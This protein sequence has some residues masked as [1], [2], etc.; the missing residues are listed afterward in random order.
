MKKHLLIYFLLLFCL[1]GFATH[2]RA[3]EITYESL[4]NNQYKITIA[5]YTKDSAPAD[6]C[7]LEIN[8]GDGTSSILSRV[9]GVIDNSQGDCNGTRRGEFV[10]ND[11]RKNLYTGTHAY[12]NAGTYILSF[13]DMNRNSGISNIPQSVN[14]PFYVQS[15]LKVAPGVGP[16]SSPV[17]TNPPIDDGC[18]N[19]R[20]EHNPGAFDA[21]GDLLTY[22]L[23]LCREAGGATVP[24]TYDPNIVQAPVTIDSLNGD[25]IWDKPQNIG[26]YNFAIQITEWRQT[27]T[28]GYRQIG[29]VVRDLQIDIKSCNN[30]PPVIQP[31]GPFCVEAGQNLNFNITAIDPDS[32]P[33]LPPASG[34]AYDD[35]TMTAFGGPFEVVFPAD[36]VYA[37]GL[38][39]VTATF[40]WDTKCEH[41]RKL[42][43]QITFKAEDDPSARVTN[44]TKLVDLYTTEIQVVAPAPKNPQAIGAKNAIDLSWD[45]SFCTDAIGYKVYRREGTY[46]FVPDP[47]ETGV[48]AYTGYKFHG[49]TP[50]VD[51]LIFKDTVDL[52]NGVQYCYMVIAHFADSSESYASVEFCSSKQVESPLITNVDI[53][54]T[55]PQNGS[56]DIKWIAPPKIDSATYPPPYSYKLYRADEIDGVNFVEI[57]NFPTIT[58][59]FYNDPALNTE[60]RGYSYKVEF[61]SGT[62]P[63]L[64]STSD[65]ASSVFLEVQPSD[66]SNILRFRHFTPW[67]NDTFVVFRENPSGS[68]VFDSLDVS[69]SNTYIDTGLVNGDSYC[70]KAL[71]IGRYTAPNTPNNLLNNSQI[72]CGSPL[73]T[74]A[75]CPPIAKADTINCEEDE[76]R[77]SWSLSADS[78]CVNDISYFNVYYK[79]SRDGD[80]PAQPMFSNITNF[81]LDITNQS[82][83]GCYAITAVDD[84]GSDPNGQPNESMI[85][86]VI[87]VE[88]CPLINFPNVFTPNGDG[89]NDFFTAINYKDVAKLNIQ[90]FNR[91]GMMV[92]ESKSPIDFFENGWDGSDI[93]T[94]QPCSDGVYFYVARFT[95]TAISEVEEQVTK[96]FVHLFRN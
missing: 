82:V 56:I 12:P 70:Y 90:V 10:G 64:A 96:G 93:N 57:G 54:N 6:R 84:A 43:Y 22:S 4:G 71:S 3:G 40:N 59:T 69:F 32:G 81:Y 65:P 67:Q 49:S 23:V 27:G 91:W 45:K 92:Y 42:P 60:D 83:A 87:C 95:P 36:S 35:V 18:L 85:G 80:F 61:Y 86:N 20:F 28:G 29:Y 11:V 25:L 47:C 78:G 8:W 48:P 5:T 24:T 7:K 88:A 33:A 50:H 89:N 74:N 14:K 75:P 26:Q 94:G 41:V 44:E 72:A 53:L 51:S 68:G 76:L 1:K 19:R 46:G 58:D 17:L 66:E 31:V 52:L 63:V 77:L 13:E 21:D 55:D 39:N 34:T 30:N 16:N 37:R 9:N 15:Q 38:Q 79:P 73:D 62:P 2:N